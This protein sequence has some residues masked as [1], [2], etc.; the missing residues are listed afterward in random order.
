[1]LLSRA[2][3]RNRRG[4]PKMKWMDG[5][6]K[7][8]SSRNLTVEQSKVVARDRSAWRKIVNGGD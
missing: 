5:V 7:A 3:G 4:R 8:L 1:M 6:K 2:E